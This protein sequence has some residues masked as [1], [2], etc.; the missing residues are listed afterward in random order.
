[1]LWKWKDIAQDRWKGK[2]S[3]LNWLWKRVAV[4]QQS[5]QR[6]FFPLP[7]FLFPKECSALGC[8][9]IRLLRYLGRLGGSMTKAYYLF[10]A[11]CVHHPR[12]PAK[13]GK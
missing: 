1:M 7:S 11:E 6:I 13:F 12:G 5:C 8:H 2:R 4:S 9:V 10:R 3:G